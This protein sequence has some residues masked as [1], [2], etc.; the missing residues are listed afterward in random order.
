MKKEKIFFNVCLIFLGVPNC[1]IFDDKIKKKKKN[2][3]LKGAKKT[4]LVV[5][6]YTKQFVNIKSY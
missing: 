2:L 3:D 5:S 6:L 1:A 4:M